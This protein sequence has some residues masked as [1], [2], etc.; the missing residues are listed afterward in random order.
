VPGRPA[1]EGLDRISAGGPGRHACYNQRP[2]HL[3][4]SAGFWCG[5]RGGISDR[6]A[7]KARADALCVAPAPRDGA[8]MTFGAPAVPA[9][10]VEVPN[11]LKFLG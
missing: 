5:R 9:K 4:E 2:A 6:R 7:W 11:P 1:A 10:M 3:A 8:A